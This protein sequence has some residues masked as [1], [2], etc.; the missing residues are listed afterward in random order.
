MARRVVARERPDVEELS[1]VL[2][3]DE[4]LAELNERY[5][6]KRGPTDVL[7]FPYLDEV[8]AVRHLG[9]VFI[10]V[11]RAHEQARRRRILLADEIVRLLVHGLLHLLGHEHDTDAG[12]RRMK[13]AE[14]RH[15]ETLA[16]WIERLRARYDAGGVA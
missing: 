10:S 8:S 1:V 2:A 12:R 16:P 3:G 15:L 6:G 9:E 14:E 11:E 5:R 4:L 13:R 7:S